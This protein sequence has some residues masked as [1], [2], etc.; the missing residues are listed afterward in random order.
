MEKEKDLVLKLASSPDFFLKLYDRDFRQYTESLGLHVTRANFYSSLPTIDELDYYYDQSRKETVY[1]HHSVF[2]LESIRKSFAQFAP[3]GSELIELCSQ[4]KLLD[5]I[6]NDQFFH[7]DP[8][9]YYSM[10]RWC[11][12]STIFEIGSGYSTMVASEALKKNGVK[13][14]RIIANEPYPRDLLYSLDNTEVR[15][16][17]AQSISADQINNELEDGDI[18]FIDSTHTV[19]EGSDVVHLICEVLPHIKKKLLVHFHDIWLPFAFPKHWVYDGINWEEQYLLYAY[20]LNNDA[21]EVIYG[22]NY[23]VKHMET[24]MKQFTLGLVGG[25]SFW[26]KIK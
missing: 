6:D 8:V 12:P 23:L 17:K 25:S 2:Q 1:D 24:E 18:L 19:K 4:G 16:V 11:R 21:T 15:K 5:F 7:C 26:F 10:V 20:L 9:A 22:T 3:F 13:Q 14:S